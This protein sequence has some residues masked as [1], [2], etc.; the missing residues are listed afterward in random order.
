[1]SEPIIDVD[2]VTKRFRVPLDHGRTLQYRFSHPVSSSRYREL[3]A[4][5]EVSMAV[6]E[7]DFIGITG[8]NG[9]GKS[10]LL[11]MISGILEPDVGSVAVRGRVSPF[12]EL[13]VGFTPD[14]SAIENVFLAGSVLGLT[15]SQV[16]SRLNDVLE[17]AELGNFAEQKLK[18]FSSGMNAR[19]A[20]SVAMLADA[21]ILLLDEVLAV[22]DERFR[23]KCL[24][25]FAH[26]KREKRTIVLVSHDLTTMEVY[27]D[28]VLLM[29]NGRV[30]A[31]GLPTDVTGEYRRIVS[32]MS[33]KERKPAR[34]EKTASG[35]RRWGAR[36]VEITSVRLL[37][38]GGR[39]HHSFLTGE[40]MTVEVGYVSNSLQGETFTCGIGFRLDSG[41][42]VAVPNTKWVAKLVPVVRV[43]SRGLIEY[44]IPSV[45]LLGG[46]Y[47]LSV[48]I[49][50][51]NNNQVYDA[52]V[53]ALD[54]RVTD[55]RGRRGVVDLG[56]EW[57][58][59]DD[60]VARDDSGA[61]A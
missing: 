1:M 45:S 4:V 49:S 12:L 29:L 33:E 48:G 7:G 27:C 38:A 17:F 54:F 19:L 9:C 55:D 28:R 26:Y 8:P 40:P 37:D 57:T 32:R 60:A 42:D 46:S 25:V 51:A 13:G 41:T 15:R 31:D 59:R 2:R 21:D 5:N 36:E 50:D 23:E 34:P 18:N 44:R 16:A 53:G 10:T 24:N 6:T 3:L 56:G 30:V 61:V 43:G 47:L 52:F 22:G 20:F 35:K 14:L 39:P 58:H 11:K